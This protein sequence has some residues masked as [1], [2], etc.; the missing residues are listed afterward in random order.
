MNAR[1]ILGLLPMCRTVGIAHDNR[2]KNNMRKRILFGCLTL[3]VAVVVQTGLA[4]PS[5]TRWHDNYGEVEVTQGNRTHFGGSVCD[6][7]TVTL[8][9]NTNSVIETQL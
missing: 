4:L 6:L 3:V 9:N 1:F 7:V 5:D 2:K 8:G